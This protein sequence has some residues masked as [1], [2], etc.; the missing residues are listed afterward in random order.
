MD[1]RS[2]LQIDPT[3]REAI[4]YLDLTSIAVSRDVTF[5]VD[6]HLILRAFNGAW[7]AFAMQNDGATIIDR[8][9]LGAAIDAVFPVVLKDYFRSAYA[10]ALRTH[11]PFELDYECSS[12]DQLRHFHQSAYPLVDAAGLVIANHLIESRPHTQRVHAF[13]QRLIDANGLIAQCCNC[14][15]LRDPEDETSWWWVP[16][17]VARTFPNTSHS[18]CPRCYDFYYPEI[19]L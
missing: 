19:D 17:A 13:T 4:A 15:K 16:E 1:Q 11:T 7:T 18:I 9:P 14:R 2:A 6:K 12:V 5:I 3:F 8:F 10:T